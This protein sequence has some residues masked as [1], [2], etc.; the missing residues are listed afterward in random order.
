MLWLEV[1]LG[2]GGE[3]VFLVKQKMKSGKVYLYEAEG[4]WDKDKKQSASDAATLAKSI[5]KA[6]R[7]K[8]RGNPCPSRRLWISASGISS[9]P[10]TTP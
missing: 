8:R 10:S 7:S 4:Y 1:S 9:S 6:A 2:R 3:N 5:P